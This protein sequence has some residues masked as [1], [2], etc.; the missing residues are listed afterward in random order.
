M[1]YDKR[2]IAFIT[3]VNDEEEY[4]ECQHYLNRLRIPDG[5]TTDTISIREAPS[6]AF[7][8]NAA[9]KKSNAKYKVYLHQDTFIK[10]IDFIEN[11]LDVFACDTEIGLVGMIGATDVATNINA[12]TVWNTGKIEE[13]LRTWNCELPL[14]GDIFTEVQAADGLLLATQYDIPWRKDIFDGWHFYDI[15]QVMEFRRGV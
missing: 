5:Y 2:K 9:M 10:N 3:C 6:M 12:I 4:M 13:S 7:G 8:Y 11:L 15:S 14:E 1:F